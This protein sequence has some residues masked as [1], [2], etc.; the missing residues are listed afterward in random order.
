[1]RRLETGILFLGLT[2]GLLSAAAVAQEEDV[3]EMHL[4]LAECI[5]IALANNSTILQ[6]KYN[7]ALA[8]AQVDGARNNF[9]P[10]ISSSWS[11]SRSVR[12]PR[13]G[14]YLDP[15][16]NLI[17]TSLGES[18]TSGSQ[19][20]STN[21]RM[22]VFDASDLATLSSRKQDYQASEL[23][24]TASRN[25]VVFQVKQRYF[26]LLQAMK[27]LEVQQEQVRVSEETLRRNATLYEI[28]SAP[29][30]D[31]L[32]A[33]SN[34]ESERAALIT[35]EN[36]VEIARSNLGFTLGLD[37]DVRIVPTEVDHQVRPLPIT[38]EQALARALAHEPSLSA[39][40]FTMQADRQALKATM[41]SIRFPSVS[42]GASYGWTLTKD[43]NFRGVE[44]L[45]MKNY[46]Y[47]V[48]LSVSL[49]IFN[50]MSTENS[51]KSQRL[52][53]LRS[54]E[55]LEQAR[56]QK[57]LNIKQVFLNIEQARRSIQAN[58]A[59]VRASEEEFKLQDQR[60]NFG[61]GTFLE[62]QNAQ[63]GMFEARNNLVQAQ[64][65]YQIRIAELENELGGP[66]QATE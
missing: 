12:G 8:D 43:E 16:T 39:R 44:D 60:Y 52:Q 15:T 9:L 20:V 46:D 38:Y 31:E 23:T 7:V 33:R 54:Q 26:Q 65:A 21:L 48:S 30:S 13:E 49:P 36:N 11:L 58:E 66:I 51:I 1:M 59:A 41:Y 55:L 10:S 50:Q 56:R 42:M 5:D 37:T 6:Q 32:A 17:V 22:S 28:G 24:M 57:A 40:R 62:R 64:Y 35:R 61:A 2:V 18:T 29:I 14:Q 45:F 19:R 4:T 27:L 3:R 63:L 47:S 34:L 25:D 53:Y